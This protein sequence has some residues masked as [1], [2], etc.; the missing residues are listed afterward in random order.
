[1]LPQH[2]STRTRAG[3]REAT[4]LLAQ[5]EPNGRSLSR[6]LARLLEVKDSAQYGVVYLTLARARAAVKNA[7]A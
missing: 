2:G 7:A 5:V 4:G 6:A 1:M 3:H